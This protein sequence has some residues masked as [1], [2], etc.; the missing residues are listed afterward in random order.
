MTKRLRGYKMLELQG[1]EFESKGNLKLLKGSRGLGVFV[2]QYILYGSDTE[3]TEVLA[4]KLLSHEQAKQMRDYLIEK[5]PLE[6][7]YE[8]RS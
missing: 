4:T 5:Y 2:R 7:G 1:N 6:V 3:E 8:S